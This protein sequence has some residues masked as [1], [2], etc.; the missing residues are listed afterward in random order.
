MEQHDVWTIFR[1]T[2][3]TWSGGR[4]GTENPQGPTANVHGPKEAKQAGKFFD[5]EEEWSELHMDM[6][7]ED[8]S[9][10][11]MGE[12]DAEAVPPEEPHQD[13]NSHGER[14]RRTTAA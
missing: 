13:A 6:D 3:W 10:A 9:W 7:G 2:C 14:S 8:D 5:P 4:E 12:D 11:G 1:V